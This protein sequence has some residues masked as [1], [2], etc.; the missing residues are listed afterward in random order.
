M[1]QENR[2]RLKTLVGNLI[3]APANKST[4]P[5][6]KATR[7]A[8]ICGNEKKNEEDGAEEAGA[9]GQEMPA[10]RIIGAIA[11]HYVRLW[12]PPG[13]ITTKEEC[14]KRGIHSSKGRGH[15]SIS[16]TPPGGIP[17]VQ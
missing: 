9:G 3:K 5:S 1:R 10:E 7:R 14:S 12:T 16:A 8:C 6:C 15:E 13:P 2:A 11:E 4:V 17:P